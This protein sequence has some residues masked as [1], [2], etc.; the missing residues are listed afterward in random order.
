MPAVTLISAPAGFIKS[1]TG[2]HHLVMDYLVEEVLGD[3]SA[4]GQA[5]LEYLHPSNAVLRSTAITES[6]S[7]TQVTAAAILVRKSRNLYPGRESTPLAADRS[8]DL[9]FINLMISILIL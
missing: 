3:P 2:S 7:F 4:P 8:Y 9:P 6:H 5:T 1:F